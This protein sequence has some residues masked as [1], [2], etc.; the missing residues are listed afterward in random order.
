MRNFKLVVLGLAVV[1]MTAAAFTAWAKKDAK[2][3]GSEECI[4][5]HESSYAA[6]V[7]GYKKTA[8]ATAM[9]DATKKPAAVKAKFD[10]DSPIKKADIKY[11][12][13]SEKSN[14][15]Y[16]DK[17][18]KV[19][20][21]KWNAMS[22]NWAPEPNAGKNGVTQCVGCHTTNFEP[23]KRTWT[24]MGV[25]CESCH[26]PGA[27]HAES[28]DAE[29]IQTMK[30]LDSKKKSMVC[31]QCHATGTDPSGK[32]AYPVD[33]LPG[34]D[35]TKSFKLKDV[36][37]GAAN[38]Q[39]NEFIKSKHYEGGMA[40]VNCHDPHGDKSKAAPQ[41]RQPINEG[42]LTCHAATIKS[43]KEHAPTAGEKATCATCHMPRGSH[44]FKK[45][46]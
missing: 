12:L 15:S 38:N 33:Y 36:A 31:G 3:V 41:L 37:E 39:Y 16:M 11:V 7:A 46:E 45:A 27:E 1:M 17:D 18:F 44:A 20:G 8:H 4:A 14:Q 9:S 2:Y 34:D 29:D 28:M 23:E 10:A 43:M 35:L 22:N 25:G 26:G 32:F 42:C 24:Q 40:C 13:G 19:L 6:L 21:G 5:C 30:G